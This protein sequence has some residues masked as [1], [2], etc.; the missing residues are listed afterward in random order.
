STGPKRRHISRRQTA[1]VGVLAAHSTVWLG[2]MIF[3]PSIR[4]ALIC[5]AGYLAVLAALAV[6]L[7][8]VQAVR[9]KA[10]PECGRCGVTELTFAHAAGRGWARV[11]DVLSCGSCAAR[12]PASRRR[13][14]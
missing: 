14:I 6:I 11:E 13:P 8:G 3:D 10:Q 5:L 2:V 4:A 1:F 12:A 7:S 9:D